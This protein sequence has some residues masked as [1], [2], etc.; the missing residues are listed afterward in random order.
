MEEHSTPGTTHTQGMQHQSQLLENEG[1]LE[2][3]GVSLH[4]SFV[5]SLLFVD[6]GMLQFAP[7]VIHGCLPCP[8]DSHSFWLCFILEL[9]SALLVGS[10]CGRLLQSVFI[11]GTRCSV[12][13]EAAACNPHWSS[14]SASLILCFRLYFLLRNWFPLTR[15]TWFG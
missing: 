5:F 3:F 10:S 6:L 12:A 9:V 14:S 1:E 15:E 13:G 7:V 8:W 2:S 11:Q 4:A